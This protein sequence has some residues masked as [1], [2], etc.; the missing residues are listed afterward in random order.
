MFGTIYSIIINP[1]SVV[2]HPPKSLTSCTS[3]GAFLLAT[4]VQSGYQG[5]LKPLSSDLYH[6]TAFPPA[7][8]P[9]AGLSLLFTPHCEEAVVR[10]NPVM[11]AV[12]E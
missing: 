12:S 2:A 10:E 11:S 9:L 3:W 6:R 4:V 1:D 7:E 8:L 5:Q